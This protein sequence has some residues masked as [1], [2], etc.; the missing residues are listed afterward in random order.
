[1]LSSAHLV[2]KS[3]Y[4]EFYNPLTGKGYGERNFGWSTLLV[5]ML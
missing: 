4:R 3:G 5:D 1:M 2:L